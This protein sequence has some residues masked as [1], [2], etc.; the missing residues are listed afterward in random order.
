M[1][2]HLGCL[3]LAFGLVCTRLAHAAGTL[4]L[5]TGLIYKIQC[6][7][8]LLVSAVGNDEILRLEAL[9]KELGCGALLKPTGKLG[10]TNLVLETSTGTLTR[11]V[12]VQGPA[13]PNARPP[14][15]FQLRVEAQGRATE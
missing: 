7:G 3:V 12:E 2:K 9:P 4:K 10:T 1:R 11:W 14:L 6:E 13:S 5:S 15:E 8:R